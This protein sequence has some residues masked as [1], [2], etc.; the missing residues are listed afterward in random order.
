LTP[1]PFVR[2]VT[3]SGMTNLADGIAVV[4]WAWLATLLTRDPVLISLVPAALRLPWFLFAIPAGI[5]TDRVDRRLL[6]VWMDV[7]RAAAFGVAAVGIWLSLPLAAAPARGVSDPTLFALIIAAALGVGIAEVFRDNAAQTMVPSI[8]P[9]DQLER[10]NGRLWSVELIGDSLIGP[11]FGAFLI[12]AWLPL[13]FAVNALAYG[14]AIWLI[15][16]MQGTFKPPG[17][18]SKN[19]RRELSDGFR[20][21]RDDPLLRLLAICT[22]IWNLLA[23][24]V[25]IA[26]VLHVQENLGV[27][28]RTYGLILAGGALGGV[29][30]GL[31]GERVVRLLGP[32]RSAQWML[33]ASAPAFF[34]MAIAPDPVSLAIVF[35]LFHF[36]G[37]IW[38]TV[39][40]SY[41]QR[42][43]PDHLL[44][45]VNSLY[46]L[47]AW[48]MM[49]V[50]L[51]LS[52]LL[53]RFGETFVTR[54]TALTLPF[55]VAGGGIVVL[56]II[57]RKP[58][59][60]GFQRAGSNH[61]DRSN[62]YQT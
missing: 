8:V 29:V 53:V 9:H 45:R 60:R 20:F 59:G 15:V 4:A 62:Q 21:L 17:S 30:A 41:R 7:F 61:P 40:V 32:G 14:V 38:N 34:A 51:I 12:A 19:W 33:A 48:G 23:V 56:A 57:A 27:G 43:I 52:G 44:G 2:F 5:I 16:R 6:I 1:S 47:L 37:V 35:A 36:T 49:P 28:A 18:Q 46:R 31:I 11:V 54:E 42:K 39:S 24:M 10:A 13:P 3:A 55:F 22:G 58:L 50:G 25:M 26:L